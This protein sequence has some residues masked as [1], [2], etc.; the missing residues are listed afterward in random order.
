MGEF[1]SL[2]QT[3]LHHFADASSVEYST[4]SYLKV[5]ASNG[6]IFC[7]F[8]LGKSRLAPSKTVSIPRLEL[9]AATMATKIDVSLRKNFGSY[10]SESV[11]WTDSMS[12]LYMIQ[13]S[14]KRFSV[15]VSNRLAQI[16][17]RSTSSQWR[18]VPS[19]DNPTDDGT[20]FSSSVN[21][22]LTGPSFL[23]EPESLWPQPPHSL[24][25]LPAEFEIVKR[26]VAG[27]EVAVS[28][29][30]M[31]ERFARFSSFYRLKRIVA[32][33]LR[34]K[35]RLLR[36][37]VT[38]GPLTVDEM[39]QEEMTVVAAVQREAITKDYK[40]LETQNS[41]SKMFNFFYRNSILYTS[42]VCFESEV[43]YAMLL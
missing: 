7:N 18:F 35:G 1:D 13:N 14:S 20:R 28:D 4:V 34:L 15:F 29:R 30:D 42:Q 39:H 17:D 43:G 21:C 33:I 36:R 5:I 26:T 25:D 11:F 24:Y 19:S 32:R 22:W 40:R 23:Q 41:P 27:T 16:E 6:T 31:E 12:V 2:F 8:L 38:T 10:L 9:V 37:P 3:Q